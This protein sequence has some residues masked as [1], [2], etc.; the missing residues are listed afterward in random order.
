MR[1]YLAKEVS[2]DVDEAFGPVINPEE[3]FTSYGVRCYEQMWSVACFPE[4]VPD[5]NTE[6]C[7][8]WSLSKKLQE[9]IDG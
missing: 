2:V 4:V 9:K 8:A 3:T 5:D 7:K 1:I 6:L